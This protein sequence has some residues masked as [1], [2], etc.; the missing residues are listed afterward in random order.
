MWAAEFSNNGKYL[1]VAGQDKRV[2]VW[3]IISKAEDRH[4]HETEEEARNDQTAVRLS[5]PVFKT[6]PI[7]LY[8][9][10][11]ASIVD[12]S[13][14]KVCFRQRP[15][16]VDCTLLIEPQ[17][18]MI[19]YLLLLWT[20]LCASGMLRGMNVYVVSN[21]EILSRLLNFTLVMIAF[22]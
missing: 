3:A 19:S 14:S 2:R 5:A 8:E 21:M 20:K 11:T 10:H 9:G 12:L 16:K 15:Q 1:A 22:S 18:R 13:W 17:Y 4:A 6:H 7:R